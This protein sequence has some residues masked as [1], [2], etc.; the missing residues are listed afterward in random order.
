MVS[1]EDNLALNKKVIEE[2]ILASLNHFN[3]EKSPG[4]DGFT[5]HLLR[6]V[7]PS[8]KFDLIRMIQYVHKYARMGGATNSTFLS[9]IPK[10]KNASSFDRFCPIS[11]CNVSY[12]IMEKIFPT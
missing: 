8:L 1:E 2:E 11:L 12:K 7:G 4:P 10:D 3:S 9:L 6:G 5:T